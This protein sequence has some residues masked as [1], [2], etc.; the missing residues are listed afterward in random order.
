MQSRRKTKHYLT[1][2]LSLTVS[3]VDKNRANAG[4]FGTVAPEHSYIRSPDSPAG[5]IQDLHLIINAPVL[6]LHH[7]LE[8]FEI[9]HRAARYT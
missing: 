7:S 3:L 5:D 2:T 4:A 6:N 9:S 8:N 1:K